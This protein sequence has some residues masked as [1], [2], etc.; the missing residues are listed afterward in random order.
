MGGTLG[1]PFE[2]AFHVLWSLL[3]KRRKGHHFLF[4]INKLF[5]GLPAKLFDKRSTWGIKAAVRY[6]PSSSVLKFLQ[7]IDLSYS[8][9]SPNRTTI[10]KM[11]LHNTEIKGFKSF[12]WQVFLGI[13]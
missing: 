8:A 12:F 2:K 5:N 4:T 3:I 10:S 13:L 6:D 9:T 11:R 1:I 7:L